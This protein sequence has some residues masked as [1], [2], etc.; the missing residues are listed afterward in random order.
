[1]IRDALWYAAHRLRRH[2]VWRSRWTDWCETCHRF[3]VRREGR[4]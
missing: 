3:R 4:P 1:M 2:D